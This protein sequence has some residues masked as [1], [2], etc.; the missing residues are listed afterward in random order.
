MTLSYRTRR[1]IRRFLTVA[2]I[3]AITGL[4]VWLCWFFWLDRF[5]VYTQNAA[6]F[7][8]TLSAQFPEGQTAPK[9]E[10]GNS[11]TIVYNDR[12][13]EDTETVVEQTSISGYYIDLDQLKT[14]VSAVQAKLEKLPPGTAVMLDVKNTKGYFYYSTSVGTTTST[15]V[16]IEAMDSLLA[17]LKNSDLYTIARLPAFRDWEYGLNHVPSGLPKKG[18][19]GSLWIDD[20]GCYWLNPANDDALGYLIRI[21][22]ELR[23]LGFDEVVFT[24]FRFPYTDKIVFEGDKAQVISDAAATMVS[25]CATDRFCVSFYSEDYAFPLPDGSTRLYLENVDAA[26]L[27]NVVPQVQM[28]DPRIHLLFLTTVNDTRFND[29]CVLRPLDNAH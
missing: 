12:R 18:G 24:D 1:T 23:S 20:T 15:D 13:N 6:M 22:T 19:N 26:D 10:S 14:D 16:D 2:V 5:V 29:Y 17:Y 21:T 11:I 8:F 7:D 9:P 3:V 28:S 25:T 4:L 27:V